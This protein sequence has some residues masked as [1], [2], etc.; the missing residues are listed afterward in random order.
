M[1]KKDDL[2]KNIKVVLELEDT[3]LYD[4]KLD[5]FVPSAISK[6]ANEG[7]PNILDSENTMH[8]YLIADYTMC[9]A[10]EVIKNIDMEVSLSR[11]KE[12]SLERKIPLREAMKRVK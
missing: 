7:I 1:L 9:L 11:I 2:I 8:D 5:I 12:M 3:T 10:Y 4:S 6:L